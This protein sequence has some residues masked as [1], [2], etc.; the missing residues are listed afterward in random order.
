MIEA[1]L[2]MDSLGKNVQYTGVSAKVSQIYNIITM[3]PGSDPLNP[4]KWCDIRSYYYQFNEENILRTLETNIYDQIGQ[5][6]P[7][8]VSSVQCRAVK[9]LKGK[10]ILH[11][12]V[13]MPDTKSII[14]ST[15][16]E[17][18]SLNLINN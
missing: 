15:N 14:V 11:V 18:S 5:Y 4:Y 16:G 9:N 1:S 2:K 3:K 12:I 6:T 7:Y 8:L 10:Y 13:M 17:T